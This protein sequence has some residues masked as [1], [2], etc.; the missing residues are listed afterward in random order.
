[1]NA[2]LRYRDRTHVSH[3]AIHGPKR[4]TTLRDKSAHTHVRSG[5]VVK[6]RI[7]GT[8]EDGELHWLGQVSEHVGVQSC[9][10]NPGFGETGGV[11]RRADL[12]FQ[13]LLVHLLLLGRLHGEQPQSQELIWHTC[14]RLCVCRRVGYNGRNIGIPVS[15]ILN[16]QSVRNT[17]K[18]CYL[19]P[20]PLSCKGHL[21]TDH[22][23]GTCCTTIRHSVVACDE[24]CCLGLLPHSE[25]TVDQ[26]LLLPVQLHGLY[27]INSTNSLSTHINAELTSEDDQ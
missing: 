9:P 17:S 15:R 19:L 1:M 12:L 6:L 23:R 16:S 4:I 20:L 10:L 11:D 2:I 5:G 18:P 21:L 27:K 3:E 7:L 8:A 26:V 25:K 22:G 14:L 13:D 24:L